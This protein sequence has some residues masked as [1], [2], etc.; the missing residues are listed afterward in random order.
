MREFLESRTELEAIFLGDLMGF[1][2]III[3]PQNGHECA[4]DV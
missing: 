1:V 4:S 3:D 2:A